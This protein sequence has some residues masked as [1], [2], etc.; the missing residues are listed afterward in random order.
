MLLPQRCAHLF[1][2]LI[3]VQKADQRAIAKQPGTSALASLFEA[4]QRGSQ[5][6]CQRS[7]YQLGNCWWRRP[8]IRQWWWWWCR[9]VHLIIW[10]R[11]TAA[12]RGRRRRYMLRIVLRLALSLGSGAVGCIALSERT[13]CGALSSSSLLHRGNGWLNRQ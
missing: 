4:L 9:V 2:E 1:A 13:V 7:G 10:H 6:W 12:V 11:G 5:P 8:S 3:P